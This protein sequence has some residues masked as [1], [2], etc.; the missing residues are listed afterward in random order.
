MAKVIYLDL[1]LYMDANEYFQNIPCSEMADSEV[2]IAEIQPY[3]IY[4]DVPIVVNTQ[5]CYAKVKSDKSFSQSNDL[6][7][8]T[9]RQFIVESIHMH[10]KNTINVSIL[11]QIWSHK[12]ERNS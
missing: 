7:E 8:D 12:L 10:A 6:T 4:E 2:S 3:T 11:L 1:N 5:Q 9:K